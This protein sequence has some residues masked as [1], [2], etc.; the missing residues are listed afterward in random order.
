MFRILIISVFFLLGGCGGGD[1][2]TSAPELF[3]P[4][5]DSSYVEPSDLFLVEATQRDF[6]DLNIILETS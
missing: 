1:N 2:I 6:I 3:D 4:P 5:A